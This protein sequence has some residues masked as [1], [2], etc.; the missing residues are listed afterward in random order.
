MSSAERFLAGRRTYSNVSAVL[1][2]TI[3][4]GHMDPRLLFTAD[5]FEPY[6]WA[7]KHLLPPSCFYG[8][9]IKQRRLVHRSTAARRAKVETIVLCG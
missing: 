2:D 8:Q 7:A 9:V 4:R 5:G 3:A 6:A 1:S